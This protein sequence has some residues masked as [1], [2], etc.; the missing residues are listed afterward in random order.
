[1]TIYGDVLDYHRKV[2]WLGTCSARSLEVYRNPR[3]S[4]MLN[5]QYLLDLSHDELDLVHV[6]GDYLDVFSRLSASHPRGRSSFEFIL[7]RTPDL[8]P[9]LGDIW[10][11]RRDVS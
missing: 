8:L 9:Y 1:M 2:V 4:V 5:Y 3:G 6:I 11:R 10:L 7:W